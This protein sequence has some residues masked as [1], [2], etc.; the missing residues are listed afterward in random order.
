MSKRHL[1]QV[2]KAGLTLEKSI[3]VMQSHQQ[4]KIEKKIT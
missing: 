4:A 1:F 3:N 2:H